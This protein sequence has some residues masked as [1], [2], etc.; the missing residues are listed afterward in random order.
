LL[1]G[2]NDHIRGP[3]HFASPSRISKS[4]ERIRRAGRRRRGALENQPLQKWAKNTPPSLL[5][6][7]A[8]RKSPA[9]PHCRPVQISEF[10]RRNIFPPPVC[11]PFLSLQ[12]RDPDSPPFPR[13]FTWRLA[14]RSAQAQSS[15]WQSLLG[16]ASFSLS[17][18]L[19]LA[20]I[21]LSQGPFRRGERERLGR[22]VSP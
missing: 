20:A 7:P 18:S 1:S 13:V 12:F 3:A 14:E 16:T 17:A 10:R 9:S 15:Q 5:L 21:A 8:T 4:S 2:R 22:P 19:P 11:P 6:V